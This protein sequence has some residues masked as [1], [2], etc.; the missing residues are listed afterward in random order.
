MDD[1]TVEDFN[2]IDNQNVEMTDVNETHEHNCKEHKHN[3]NW[4]TLEELI[5]NP[6]KPLPLYTAIVAPKEEKDH[7]VSELEPEEVD[8][9]PDTNET[10][11]NIIDDDE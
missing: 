6:F 5:G 1:F 11:E 10:Q 7:F 3:S 8:E 2:T 4:G 9:D